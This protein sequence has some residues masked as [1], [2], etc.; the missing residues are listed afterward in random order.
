METPTYT[1]V[2]IS[3]IDVSDM[4][5]RISIDENIDD[6]IT[7]ISKVGLI[8]PIL[9]QKKDLQT[10]RIISGFKRVAAAGRLELTAI[11]AFEYRDSEPSLDLF[12]LAVHANQS[13]KPLN[14]IE[15]SIVCSQLE[16]FFQTSKSDIVQHYLPSL[17]YGCNPR[18]LEL[19]TNLHT[20]PQEWKKAVIKDQ[21]PLDIAQHIL[22]QTSRDRELLWFLFQ[23]L[24]LGKNRQREFLVLLADVCRLEDISLAQLTELEEVASILKNESWTPSQKA[25]HLK[26]WLWSK[27]YPEYTKIKNEFNH[28]LSDARLPANITIKASPFF[29][30]DEFVANISF[31]SETEFE[32]ALTTLKKIL[33]NGG[34]KK[35]LS[36]T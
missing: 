3:Q 29:E 9:L 20:L 2:E 11:P 4:T 8:T 15:L 5:Y 12:T 13:I 28:I 32:Y 1:M 36:L 35:I 14:S 19:V 26:E 25:D 16:S 34:I 7:S 22:K 27:R 33:S 17:G 24:R 6:L 31:R 23:T 10:Y 30:S 21:V 18:V